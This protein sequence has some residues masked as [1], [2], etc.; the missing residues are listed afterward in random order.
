MASGRKLISWHAGNDDVLSPN[1]HYRNWYTMTG[2]ARSEGLANPET[3]TRFFVVPGTSHGQGQL[4]QEVD[5]ATAIMAWVEN[6]VAP[7]QLTYSFQSGAGS[8]SIPV[9]Q[10]PLYPRYQG[11]GDVNLASSFSCVP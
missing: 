11:A 9:C 7:T 10:H 4:L 5:W 6:G 3:A 2:L 8:R 1:D